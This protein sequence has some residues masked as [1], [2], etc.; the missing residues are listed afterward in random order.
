MF[1]SLKEPKAEYA[2]GQEG[3]RS[4]WIPITLLSMAEPNVDNTAAGRMRA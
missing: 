4:A 3:T 2:K 1:P